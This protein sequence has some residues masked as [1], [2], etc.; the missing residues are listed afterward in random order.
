MQS[1]VSAWI[2]GL[3]N[4]DAMAVQQLW[5]RYSERLLRIAMAKIRHL[6]PHVIDPEDIVAS[7]FESLWRGAKEGRLQDVRNRDELWWLLLSL[8]HNKAVSQIRRETAQKRGGSPE[9]RRTLRSYCFEELVSGEPTAEELAVMKEEYE[10]LLGLLRDKLLRQIAV[11]RVEGF[12]GD[13][14]AEQLDVS[15]ATVRRKLQLIRATWRR[16]MNE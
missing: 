6:P 14:I 3:K 16:E 13:E 9:N 1:S 2:E 8:T 7:A 5:Y 10:R 15:I 4:D 11:L 12:T